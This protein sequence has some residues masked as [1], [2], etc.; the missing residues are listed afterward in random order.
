MT[1]SKLVD[2]N[3]KWPHSSNAIKTNAPAGVTLI[4]V[5]N[6]ENAQP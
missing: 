2:S 3:L 4:G 1:K 5:N 6:S